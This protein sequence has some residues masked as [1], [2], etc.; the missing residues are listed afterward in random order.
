MTCDTLQRID[1]SVDLIES[2]FNPLLL[3]AESIVH[4][5]RVARMLPLGA[6]DFFGFECRLA[7][8]SHLR[9]APLI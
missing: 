4:I 3:P 5:R 7:P 8:R 6:V 9:T 1:G 2:Y